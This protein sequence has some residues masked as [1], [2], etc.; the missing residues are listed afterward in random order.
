MPSGKKIFIC[1]NT[2]LPCRYSLEA[3]RFLLN[4]GE[5]E[6]CPVCHKAD[7]T[8]V[9]GPAPARGKLPLLAGCAA[10]LLL[11]AGL[12]LYLN[13]NR[14][15]AATQELPPE[16]PARDTAAPKE[17]GPVKIQDTLPAQ[18]A[19]KA[20]PETPVPEAIKKTNRKQYRQQR[21][22]PAGALP[23]HPGDSD[24]PLYK[25]QHHHQQQY[26]VPKK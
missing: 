23:A 6:Q 8:P 3:T 16:V 17:T 26:N 21:E 14:S 4:E 25:A 1:N 18:V 10:A 19:T 5:E 7:I 11:A 22:T 24:N 9:Q 20:P 12:L 2:D 13:K 15:S